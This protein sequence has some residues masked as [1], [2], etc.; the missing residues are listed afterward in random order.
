M[1]GGPMLRVGDKAPD[2]SLKGVL[3]GNIS[4]YS[5]Q[6]YWGKWL[7]LFFYPADF[8]FICP[9]EVSGF[10]KFAREFRLEGAEILGV[11]V[12][13]VESHRKWA[14]ELG[15]LEYPLLSD[16]EKTVSRLYGVLDEKEGVCLRA[17]FIINP[18]RDITYLV[19]SHANVGRSVEETLRVLKALRSERLCPSDW[20]PGEATG[21]LKL[22][23]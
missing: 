15:G 18:T 5:I 13:P 4:D 11:S 7:I 6:A 8:T 21:D 16:E 23:Y 20:K 9:T 2:F 1:S 3:R 22:R 12:D 10:S 17:T 19:V 14:V